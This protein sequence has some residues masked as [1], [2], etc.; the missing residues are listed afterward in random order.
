MFN[1]FYTTATLEAL[2]DIILR[3]VVREC[4]YCCLLLFVDRICGQ[5]L[6][7]HMKFDSEPK[8]Y[9]SLYSLSA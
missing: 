8:T 4:F 1:V 9:I 5:A 6:M 7:P 3:T 2:F